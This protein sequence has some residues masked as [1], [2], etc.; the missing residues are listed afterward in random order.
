MVREINQKISP[1]E[2]PGYLR[3]MADL[4]QMYHAVIPTFV[5]RDYRTPLSLLHPRALWQLVRHRLVANL[6][7]R[8]PRYV[9]DERLRTL[10]SFQTMYLGLSPKVAR[11]VYGVS[12][13]VCLT[14]RTDPDDAP[15]GCEN[16]YALVP[17]PNLDGEAVEPHRERI[18]S[19]LFERVG[20]DPS[21]IEFVEMRTPVDWQSLGLW[22]GATF[23]IA[24]TF[25]QS[26]C[27]RP[28]VRSPFANLYFVGA[29]T[30]PGNGIPMVLISAELAASAINSSG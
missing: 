1:T 4:C 3:L 19:Y 12:F 8:I 9:H 2:V 6:W 24:A 28:S 5:Q 17:V 18:L 13:Y 16:L 11:W 23:G 15:K 25:F 14:N 20:L 22:Q 21:C 30:H 7:R 10:F 29:S 27:F 26:T